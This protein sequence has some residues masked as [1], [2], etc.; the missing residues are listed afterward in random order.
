MAISH[1]KL[2]SFVI[3]SVRPS[4]GYTLTNSPIFPIEINNEGVPTGRNASVTHE[5]AH[6]HQICRRDHP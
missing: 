1:S 3:D 2:P 6:F 4:A 5:S